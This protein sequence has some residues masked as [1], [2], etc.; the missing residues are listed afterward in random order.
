MK[1]TLF[2]GDDLDALHEY[3]PDGSE[4]LFYLDPPLDS[5]RNFNGRTDGFGR[6]R[7]VTARRDT[8]GHSQRRVIRKAEL[9]HIMV[10]RCLGCIWDGAISPVTS[11]EGEERLRRRRV[12]GR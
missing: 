1:N 3:L 4:D 9:S 2:Y 7:G 11:L 12:L 8:E 10:K 6:W 5:N